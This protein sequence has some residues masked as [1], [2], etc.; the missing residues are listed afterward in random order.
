MSTYKR[1]IYSTCKIFSY[2]HSFNGKKMLKITDVNLN[3]RYK[4]FLRYNNNNHLLKFLMNFLFAN[5]YAFYIIVIY[6]ISF[7]MIF[8]I[9]I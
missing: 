1:L 9:I 2:K 5:Y 3:F 6:I 7:L 8:I 4:I